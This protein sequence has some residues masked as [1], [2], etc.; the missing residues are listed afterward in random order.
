MSST[1]TKRKRGVTCVI[2]YY[3]GDRDVV[4]YYADPLLDCQHVTIPF[5]GGC[6]MIYR[7][8]EHD[9]AAQ[10]INASDLNWY[11]VNLGRVLANK[12]TREEFLFYI[13]F[14]PLADVEMQSSISRLI[15]Q[16]LN[17]KDLVK[18]GGCSTHL[19]VC[20][21]ATAWQGRSGA[22]GTGREGV[23][24]QC[25]KRW[26]PSGGSSAKRW[27]SAIDAVREVW[28]SMQATTTFCN[29]SA[30]D[31]LP[32]VQD[33]RDCGIYCDPP[34]FD[35]GDKYAFPFLPTDHLKLCEQLGRFE[36]T[37][38]VIRY[39]ADDRVR[40]IYS[41]ASRWTIT[42]ISSRNQANNSVDELL[43]QNVRTAEA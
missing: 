9:A 39:G 36:Q 7:L 17:L 18:R 6:S 10:H 19:A 21:F 16:S 34:W 25:S 4:D 31:L 2:P 5:C 32:D 20:Y 26:I 27:V 22:A 23:Q 37:R 1:S 35:V 41:D 29:R 12:E 14:M 28:G 24:T 40:Q 11:A 42:E 43:I 13:E 3:G 15:Q 30:F 33:S 38:V 8:S